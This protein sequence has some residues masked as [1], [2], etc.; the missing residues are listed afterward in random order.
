MNTL[1]E[2][3]IMTIV[4]FGIRVEDALPVRLRNRIDA[5]ERMIRDSLTGTNY[6]EGHRVRKC[7]EFD[8]SWNQGTWTFAQRGLYIDDDYDQR[9]VHIQAGKESFLSWVWGNVF[10]LQFARSDDEGTC[11]MVTDFQLEPPARRVV[12]HG[13][14]YCQ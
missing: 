14:Y 4:K 11:F 10:G 5:I 2:M 13:H 1:E 12:F 7:L 8:I 6:Y 9:R 3:A